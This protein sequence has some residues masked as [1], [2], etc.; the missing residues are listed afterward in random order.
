MKV[1]STLMLPDSASSPTVLDTGRLSPVSADRSMSPVP[2]TSTP[3]S[4]TF[5]PGAMTTM[6][7]I[8]T[9]SGAMVMSLP[10]FSTVTFS[11]R[12]SSICL[13]LPRL[14]ATARPWRYSPSSKRMT[15]AQLSANS[16][17]ANA[18]SDAMLMR[19]SSPN[20][21][22]SRMLSIASSRTR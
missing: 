7:S 4:E 12:S 1:A 6:S 14:L 13:M 2:S 9:S 18:P 22:P 5:S 3:S 19:N 20:Q 16:P 11:G 21:S 17:M 10:S 8:C 15:T